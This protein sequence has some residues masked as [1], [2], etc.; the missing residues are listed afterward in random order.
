MPSYIVKIKDKYLEWSTIVDAPTTYGE[1]LET[2]KKRYIER[3]IER[4][5]VDLEKR[6]ARVEKQGTSC[7]TRLTV[8]VLI[9]FNR[10]GDDES[11]LSIDGIYEKYCTKVSK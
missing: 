7:Q 8:E 2:F 6:L 9:E 10:A 3:E 1:D 5:K 4:I 11:E